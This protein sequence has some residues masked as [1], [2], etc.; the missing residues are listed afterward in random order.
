MT[1]YIVT[2]KSDQVEVCRY[3]AAEPTVS[4]ILSDSYPFDE[5]DHTATADSDS[6]APV[7]QW[8]WTPLE[9]LRKFTA[10]E[11]ITIRAAAKVNASL[12]DFMFLLERATE[13]HSDNPDVVNGLALLEAAGL[14]A[15]GRAAEILNGQYVHPAWSHL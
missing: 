3:S 1:T 13:V 14:L 12:D 5:Y 4:P 2:R 15:A 10:A 7:V 11:R 6:P 9:F 8:V